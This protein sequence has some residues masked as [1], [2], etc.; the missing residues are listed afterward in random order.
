MKVTMRRVVSST[1]RVLRLTLVAFALAACSQ[2]SRELETQLVPTRT[3]APRPR[4]TATSLGELPRLTPTVTPEPLTGLTLENADRLARVFQLDEPPPRHIYSAAN[5]R[6][7]VFTSRSF[8]V[9][10]A[11]T[12]D[13]QTRTPVQLN[14]EAAPIFWYAASPNGKVGAIMQ[15]DGTVDIYDLDTSQIVKTLTVPRP[16]AEI[17]SD[18]ALNEDGSELAVVSRGELRRI[19]L[20][21]A[22]VV[23]GGQTLPPL[24]QAIRFAEDASRVAA[25]QPTG[26]I[27]IVSAVG[28]APPITLTGVFTN[29][30]VEH[31]S[32]SPNGAKF[33]ASG[34]ESLAVWDLSGDRP[35]LQ[36]AFTDLGGAVEPIF[37]RTGRFMAVLISPSVLLYDL[38]DD[39]PRAQFRLAGNLPVWSVNFDPTGERLFVAGSGELASFDI[40]TRRALQSASRP[41]ITRSVFSADGKALF[42]WS[43]AYP[44]GDVA[45]FDAQTWA[46]RDRLLHHMPVIQVEPDRANAYVATVTLDFGIFV[47]RVRDGRRLASIAAPVTDTARALLCFAPDDRSLIYLDGRRIVAYDIAADRATGDF[48]L[49]FAPRSISGCNNEAAVL[50]A[51]GEQDIRVFDLEGRVVATMDALSGVEEAGALYLSEDGRRLA[52][53]SPTQLTIWDVQAQEAL[54]TAQLRRAPLAGLFSPR[55]D[56]FIINFGDDVDVLDVASGKVVSLDL[57]KGSS[58]TALF[59]RDSRLVITAL[60]IPTS[61]TAEQPLD[62]RVFASGE[63]RLWDAQTGELLRRI[64]TQDLPYV[65]AISA[66]GA[67]FATHARTNAMTIWGRSPAR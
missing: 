21:D 44:S 60:M 31:L 39:E 2:Q 23:S 67:F 12:L 30:A 32:F 50:A 3:L 35:V 16:S 64:Q 55:G 6:L 48:E 62:R 29:T 15:P 13:V 4:V 59:P 51:A 53:L 27:V 8:E 11:D 26:D 45:I 1:S 22:Q 36:K 20:D 19:R 61:E 9:I 10:V 34:G 66:D 18:I 63:L 28:S 24:T 38:Q 42:T 33:G 17:A 5:D 43:T 58:A 40:A 7:V 57:P 49:P 37:D 47:W 56:R 54:Q 46:V 65:G 41:P 14:D 52:V 25:V